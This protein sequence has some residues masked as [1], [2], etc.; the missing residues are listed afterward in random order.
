[1]IV[2]CKNESENIKTM[3]DLFVY[4]I[5]GSLQ[6]VFEWIPISSE[7]VVAVAA[8]YLN[9]KANPVELALFLH[10]GTLLAA[11]CFYWRDWLKVFLFKDWKLIKFL[12]IT[13]AVSLPMGFVIARAV[14][15]S[16]LGTGLLFITGACLLFTAYFQAKKINLR[17]GMGKLALI[18]GILQGI[19]ALPGFSRSGSTIFGLSLGDLPPGQILRLSYLMSVPAVV[20]STAYFLVFKPGTFTFDVWPAIA[21]SFIIGLLSLD[22]LTK[23]SAKINFTKF[24][25][26]FALLCFVGVF[27]EIILK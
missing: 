23:I 16:A 21:A 19:A 24:A 17:W 1:M 13:T 4:L 25:L 22:F 15:Q 27:L 2:N 20:A 10:L 3:I 6:G 12:A 14:T 18:G 9:V 8:Q 7:G 26:V 11:L 5:L